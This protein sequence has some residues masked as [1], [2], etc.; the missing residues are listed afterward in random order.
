MYARIFTL[1]IAAA[2]SGLTSAQRVRANTWPMSVDGTSQQM[3]PNQNQEGCNLEAELILDF[4]RSVTGPYKPRGHTHPNTA[5]YTGSRFV[6]SCD[7]A[8]SPKNQ[9]DL[10]YELDRIRPFANQK[11]VLPPIPQCAA[12]PSF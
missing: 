12:Y 1:L 8:L 6:E 3:G 11:Y 7:G 5:I 4:L 10:C 9:A 2:T